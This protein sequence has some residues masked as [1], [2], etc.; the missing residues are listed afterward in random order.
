MV[1]AKKSVSCT[2]RGTG[3]GAWKGIVLVT[4]ISR[5]ILH[6][7]ELPWN[8]DRWD[9]QGVRVMHV[10]EYRSWG[11]ERYSHGHRNFTWHFAR[12]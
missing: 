8:R 5:G 9:A 4:G 2:W 10:A 12:D 3:A 1:T 7:T 11:V 6:V